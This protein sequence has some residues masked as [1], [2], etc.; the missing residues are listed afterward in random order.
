MST[1]HVTPLS[2]SDAIR[3][4]SLTVSDPT[5]GEITKCAIRMGLVANGGAAND[6]GPRLLSHE[7]YAELHE[8]LYDV[9]ADY[10]R[11]TGR[12][13]Q[14]LLSTYPW[15]TTREFFCNWCEKNLHSVEVVYHPF[16]E[17]V[18]TGQ[19]TM[20]Q[21][22]DWLREL[23]KCKRPDFTGDLNL[24]LGIL[25]QNACEKQEVLLAAKDADKKE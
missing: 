5:A 3:L 21:F 6:D 16:D 18:M 11:F 25:F 2:L 8:V 15:L 10:E 4:G 12:P 23:E 22:C 24:G 17:H 9:D 7:E 1:D 19:V 14:S 13:G 20:D